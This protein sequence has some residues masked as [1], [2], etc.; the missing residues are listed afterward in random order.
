MECYVLFNDISS[1]F[2]HFGSMCVNTF[3]KKKEYETYNNTLN[4]LRIKILFDKAKSVH[5][6]FFFYRTIKNIT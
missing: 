3:K 1:R 4:Y 2:N 5:F 6:S